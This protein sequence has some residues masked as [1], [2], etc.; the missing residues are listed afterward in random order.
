MTLRRIP[1][2][3]KL[4]LEPTHRADPYPFYAAMPPVPR[5]IDGE[6]YVVRDYQQVVS[7]LHD[8]RLS[9]AIADSIDAHAA[10]DCVP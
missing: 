1:C 10:E 4:A 7:L 8:P 3:F 9:S 6:R 2:P 5:R